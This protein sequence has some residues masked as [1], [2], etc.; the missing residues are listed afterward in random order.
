VP[1]DEVAAAL[2]HSTPAVTARHYAH[3]IRK[4]FSPGMCAPLP[5]A[6]GKVIPIAGRA[7][8]S[9][10]DAISANGAEWLRP[11]GTEVVR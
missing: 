7:A 5:P 10:A 4:T 2:G 8:V 6:G 9:P 1:L 11:T 3:F